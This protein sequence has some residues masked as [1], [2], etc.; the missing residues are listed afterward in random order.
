[1]GRGETE[2]GELYRTALSGSKRRLGGGRRL[3]EKSAASPPTASALA[4]WRR[5]MRVPPQ[6]GS[7]RG[8]RGV[9][10]TRPQPTA[11]PV[12]GQ[13]GV[14]GAQPAAEPEGGQ[15]RRP[16]SECRR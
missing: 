14:A 8:K 3:Y 16:G 2:S 9:P 13:R 15:T 7:R 1:M 10:S 5:L 12:G 4:I 11:E 6:G